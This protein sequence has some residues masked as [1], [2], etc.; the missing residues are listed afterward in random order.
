MRD[1]GAYPP[2]EQSQTLWN[3]SFELGGW[4]ASK[5]PL[6]TNMLPHQSS[7]YSCH[8]S[9]SWTVMVGLDVPQYVG[10]KAELVL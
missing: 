6:P 5:L 3:D 7:L 1:A 8:R 9:G 4:E 10:R 2:L